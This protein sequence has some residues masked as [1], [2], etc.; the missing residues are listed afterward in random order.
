MAFE[1]SEQ[2][3]SLT[4]FF[5][6]VNVFFSLL[7]TF[8]L[9]LKVVAY[10]PVRTLI[11]RWNVFDGVIVLVSLIELAIDALGSV[12]FP[13]N[14]TVLRAF[15]VFRLTRLLKLVPHSEGLQAVFHTFLEALPV[16]T[17]VGLLL[18]MV[19]F[20]Y[21]VLAVQIFSAVKPSG[22]EMEEWMCFNTFG[23]TFFTLF[24]LSTG[25][26]WNAIMHEVMDSPDGPG[27]LIAVGF[28]LSFQFLCVF[29]T[30]NLFI[31]VVVSYTQKADEEKFQRAQQ[32]E[33]APPTELELED[34]YS[35]CWAW[36]EVEPQ[37]VGT[38]AGK[39]EVAKVIE[40]T[41]YPLGAGGDENR[42][43]EIVQWLD[44]HVRPDGTRSNKI[45]LDNIFFTA[46]LN[47]LASR[48]FGWELI[49][50]HIA[51]AEEE[52]RGDE[53]PPTPSLGGGAVENPM[54]LVDAEL[55]NE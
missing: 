25:E 39:E 31:S 36:A 20:I 5:Y 52:R 24:V 51:D 11:D 55:G 49:L 40:G 29:L 27:E 38:I 41:R 23:Q 1:H 17:N 37:C 9:V 3:D 28:F 48:A 54:A 18:F 13:I 32:T 19:F 35:F 34:I 2:A 50:Q 44:G 6:G 33:D 47:H 22:E 12:N 42:L 26:H 21:A 15:R 43:A 7:F 16:L 53:T 45:E 4:N 30:L 8:E 14:P 46:L 10:N